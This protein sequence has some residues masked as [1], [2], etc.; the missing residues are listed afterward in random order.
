M[1]ERGRVVNLFTREEVDQHYKP[2]KLYEPR[3]GSARARAK[4]VGASSGDGDPG[5]EGYGLPIDNKALI[6]A[7]L[8]MGL[9]SHRICQK[10]GC[11]RVD[12]VNADRERS[13]MKRFLNDDPTPVVDEQVTNPV[14]RFSLFPPID[15]EESDV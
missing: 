14:E 1:S 9:D 12:V 3:E 5:D 10:L 15:E 4:K 6:L 11:S 2:R 7:L 13:G 8:D